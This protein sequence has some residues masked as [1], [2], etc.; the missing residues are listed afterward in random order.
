MRMKAR[1]L[2][3]TIPV[4]ACLAVGAAVAIRRRGRK[5]RERVMPDEVRTSVE[6]LLL[7]KGEDFVPDGLGTSLYERKLHTLT[8]RQ[9]VAVY[10]LVKLGEGM[11]ARGIDVAH[12]SIHD[13]EA[14]KA[15]FRKALVTDEGRSEIIR[16]LAGFGWEVL[17]STLGDAMSISHS[18]SFAY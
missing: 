16:E 14:S 15:E 13:I 8:D 6:Q 11:R 2:L 1:V 17:H 18:L 9:L 5:K 10:A 4:V 12:L 7:L 3:A